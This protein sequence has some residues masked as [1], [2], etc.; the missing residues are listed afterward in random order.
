MRNLLALLGL[1]LLAFLGL[2]WYLDWYRV[3]PKPASDSGHRSVEID[4]NTKKI[5][6]DV[7]RGVEAGEQKL[8]D[9][10]NK[11]QPAAPPKPGR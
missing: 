4:I 3:T 7:H 1:V 2:G 9:L 11:G 8:H 10:L 6:A 5:G